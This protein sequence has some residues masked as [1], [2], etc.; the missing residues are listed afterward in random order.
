MAD[1]KALYHRLPLLGRYVLVQPA[2]CHQLDRV[3]MAKSAIER[4]PLEQARQTLGTLWFIGSGLIF[5]ILIVQTL[6]NAFGDR[7]QGVWGW[8]LPNFLPTLLLMMGVFAGSALLDETESDKMLVRRFFYRITF[9]LSIAHLGAVLLT[10]LSQ[11][12][13][14]AL[15]GG[16]DAMAGFDLSNLWL[17]PLQGLVAAGIGTLFFSKAQPKPGDQAAFS[18]PDP[19]APA[20]SPPQP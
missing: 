7:I 17:G 20:V 15:N 2:V 14:P 13:L 18:G 6:G 5:V 19:A 12:F 16:R 9:W 10:M 1:P 11:P 4:I 3:F 8:A